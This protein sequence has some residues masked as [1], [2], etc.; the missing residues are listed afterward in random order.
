M[1]IPNSSIDTWS[2]Y[3]LGN[4]HGLCKVEICLWQKMRLDSLVT[5]STDKLVPQCIVQESRRKFTVDWLLSKTCYEVCNGFTGTLEM[6]VEVKMLGSVICSDSEGVQISEN[7]SD[8]WNYYKN[9]T[10]SPLQPLD[11]SVISNS[12]WTLHHK[13]S[14]SRIEQWVAAG[15]TTHYKMASIL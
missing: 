2:Q 13:S 11:T 8:N 4:S 15:S 1:L 5:Q 9:N 7:S 10:I 6:S 3:L 14:A 12:T